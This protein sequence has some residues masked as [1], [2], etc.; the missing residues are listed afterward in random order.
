MSNHAKKEKNYEK[1][2]YYL[3]IS[4]DSRSFTRLCGL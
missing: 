1:E 2:I 3:A 4:N